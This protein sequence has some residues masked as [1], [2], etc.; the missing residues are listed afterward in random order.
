MN[1]TLF[2]RL[3]LL[4][5]IACAM[6]GFVLALEMAGFVRQGYAPGIFLTALLLGLALFAG[7]R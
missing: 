4:I 2:N 6:T 1:T 5:C 3:L 7:E